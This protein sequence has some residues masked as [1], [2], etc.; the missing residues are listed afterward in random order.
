MAGERF[1]VR[2]ADVRATVDRFFV[3]GISIV[4]R[5][6]VLADRGSWPGCVYASV[7]LNP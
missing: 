7:E 5:H 3:A 6:R 4:Y 1:R 2:L